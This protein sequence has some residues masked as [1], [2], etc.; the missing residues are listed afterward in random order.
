MY[1]CPPKSTAKVFLLCQGSS[2]YK[3]LSK[4]V[5][6]STAGRLSQRFS[7]HFEA[8]TPS[9]RKNHFCTPCTIWCIVFCIIREVRTDKL[10]PQEAPSWELLLV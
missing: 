7:I 3:S 8:R 10:A 9:G 1:Q 6:S 2:I 4:S 5:F